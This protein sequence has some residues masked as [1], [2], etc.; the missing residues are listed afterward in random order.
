MS[1]QL[2]SIPSRPRV[3]LFGQYLVEE[4]IIPRTQLEEALTLMAATNAT[5]GELAVER[6]LLTRSQ[7]DEVNRLQH[8]IDGRWGELALTLQIGAIDAQ[9]LEDLC[10]EQQ[11]SNLRLT[12][13]LVEIG[14]LSPSEVEKHLQHFEAEQADAC[15]FSTLPPTYRHFTPARTVLEALPRFAGRLLRSPVRISGAQRWDPTDALLHSATVWVS[16]T[17]GLGVGLTVGEALGAT[18][19]RHLCSRVDPPDPSVAVGQFVGRLCEL[20]ERRAGAHT[21][22][23]VPELGQLPP[24]GVRFDVAFGDGLGRLIL[25]RGGRRTVQGTPQTPT[26]S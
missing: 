22:A 18:F 17:F 2:A 24:R 25:E 9:S 11:S 4:G 5:L 26:F 21:Q 10:W 6:G 3:R 13:A 8:H 19:L 14:A 23:T 15:P 20:V 1:V 12:D 16:G 7:A